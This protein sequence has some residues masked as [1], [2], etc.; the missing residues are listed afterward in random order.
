MDAL[1]QGIGSY[2]PA[3]V[4]W[5]GLVLFAVLE[6]AFPHRLVNARRDD[7]W[8]T[9][10]CL[11]AFNAAIVP[12]T[13]LSAVLSAQ[14]AQNNGIGLLNIVEWKGAWWVV[15]PLATVLIRS[16]SN[17]LAHYAFHKMPVLWRLHRVHH[18]D[19]N[20]DVSTGLR[21]HPAEAVLLLL[22]ATAVSIAFGLDPITLIISETLETSF[23]LFSHA[24]L[25]L[26]ARLDSWLRVLVVTPQ[27]HSVH[28]SSSQPQTDSNYG[29]LLTL[30]DRMF[31]TYR[32]P[33]S[34]EF[35]I[36][37]AEPRDSRVDSLWWQLK[38][39]FLQIG[40]RRPGA[41]RVT[42]LPNSW[43]PD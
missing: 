24:N 7:R 18:F 8:P 14:W 34:S 42:A 6:N 11:G 1:L 19:T 15:V 41:S 29:S 12:L 26:P 13:P 39:P 20:L 32:V 43:S 38:S 30:W 4:F 25:G 36:G 28:H 31:G 27:V 16:F 10:F 9:N 2:W 17:Y 5:L 40:S 3:A 22:L 35:Q 23:N 37:L 33:S 21:N